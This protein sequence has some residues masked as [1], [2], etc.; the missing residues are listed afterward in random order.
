MKI[1]FYQRSKQNFRNL[2][3]TN[4]WTDIFYQGYGLLIFSNCSNSVCNSIPMQWVVLV[5]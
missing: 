1:D 3:C 5:S 4:L 2:K